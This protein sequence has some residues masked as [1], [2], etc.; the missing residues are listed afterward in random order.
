MIIGGIQKLSLIDY[1][2]KMSATIFTRGCNFRCHYCH[3]AE[4]VVP[5]LFGAPIS[6]SYV[7][8]FLESRK[9]VLEAVAITGGEPTLQADLLDFMAKTKQMGYL[10]K[11][12]TSGVTPDVIE[13]ALRRKLV[14]YIAMDL[15]GPFEMYGAITLSY[16]KVEDVKRSI[17]LIMSSGIGYE[18]R[19]TIVRSQLSESDILHIAECIRGS[20][21]YV[22]QRFSNTKTLDPAFAREES[23]SEAELNDIK[24]KVEMYVRACSIR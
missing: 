23:Y 21:M 15:K 10:V 19:T 22:L 12:D 20:S 18:F 1:P 17:S 7:L 14:D 2:G 5:E 24:Q 6:E 16:V 4:L 9:G 8:D 13:E 11:L 3:N